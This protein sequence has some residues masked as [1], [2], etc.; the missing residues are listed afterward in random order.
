MVNRIDPFTDREMDLHALTVEFDLG[1]AS[2]KSITGYI[3]FESLWISDVGLPS[4]F[5]EGLVSVTFAET[6]SEQFSQEL[7]LSGETG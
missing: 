6:D 1:W 2:L 7:L 3:D 5:A 4:G